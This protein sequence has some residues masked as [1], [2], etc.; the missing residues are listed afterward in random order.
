MAFFQLNFIPENVSL[1]IHPDLVE[2]ESVGI[3]FSASKKINNN[4]DVFILNRL[5][6]Q[7]LVMTI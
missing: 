5:C 4:D 6:L 2:Q 1:G 7:V 3:Q